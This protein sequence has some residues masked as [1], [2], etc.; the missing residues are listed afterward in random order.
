MN[1]INVVIIGIVQGITEFLPI[2]SSG[3]L[4]I[5]QNLFGINEGQLTLDIFL[6]IGTVIPIL[7]IYWQEVKD[8]LLLKK[9]KRRLSYLIIVGIIPTGLMGFFLKDFFT[10]LFS[11][12]LNVGFMLLITGLFLYL[13]EK[14][15]VSRKGLADMKEHNAVIIGIAQGL[16]IIPGISR[17]GTTITASIFQSFDRESAAKY[18]FLVSIPVILGAGMLELKELLDNGFAGTNWV[19]IITGAVVTA[20]TGYLAIKYL[21]HVLKKGSLM[22]FAYYCW[23]LGVLIIILAGL[24]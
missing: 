9:E 14:F 4:V 8:I 1:L 3:H 19:L 24:F 5:L 16:A 12:V 17:S 23:I 7:I 20:V 18:S 6:H 10:G 22:V 2:S 21:L 13:V 11:S 15:A